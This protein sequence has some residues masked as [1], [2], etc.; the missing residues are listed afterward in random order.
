MSMRLLIHKN[1]SLYL[2]RNPRKQRW[3][4][5][6]KSPSWKRGWDVGTAG[7]TPDTI[8]GAAKDFY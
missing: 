8:L 2:P 5:S 3:A 4:E 6:P 1:V 7:A